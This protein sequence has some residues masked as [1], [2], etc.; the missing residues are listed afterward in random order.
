MNRDKAIEYIESKIGECE[1]DKRT[2]N[3]VMILY[4]IVCVVDHT[5]FTSEDLKRIEV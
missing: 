5:D 2:D 3:D 4:K 1:W